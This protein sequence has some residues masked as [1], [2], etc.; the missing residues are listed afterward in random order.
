ME[1]LRAERLARER[2]ERD[3]V[4]LALMGALNGGVEQ[5]SSFSLKIVLMVWWELLCVWC[6]ACEHVERGKARL[7]LMGVLNGGVNS[8]SIFCLNILLGY[9]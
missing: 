4:R 9:F 2:M 1:E 3:K 8:E 5:N 7:V 6:K